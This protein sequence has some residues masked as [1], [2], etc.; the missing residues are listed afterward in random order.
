MEEALLFLSPEWLHEVTRVVQGA[1]STDEKFRKLAEGF[2]VTLLYQVAELPLKLRVIHNGPKIAVLVQLAR[3]TVRKLVIG[4]EPP[5]D[6]TDF[7]VSS[8]YSVVKNIFC[9]ETNP[10]VAYID[11]QIQVEPLS[12]VYKSPRFTAKAIVT[13]NAIL[14]IA[15]KIQTSYSEEC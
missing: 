15:R 4:N 1:R 10:A 9:G 13:A 7:T 3:G 5:E 6:K 14:K 8:N 12:R 2:S 11:H